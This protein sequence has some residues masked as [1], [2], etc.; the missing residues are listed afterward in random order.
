MSW[1][2]DSVPECIPEELDPLY[3]EDSYRVPEEERKRSEE[4]YKMIHDVRISCQ[5][6]Y[7]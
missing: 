2:F 1:N 6:H 3:E 4:Q 5:F 7:G